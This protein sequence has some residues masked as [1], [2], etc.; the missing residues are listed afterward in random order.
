MNV[1]VD[2]YIFKQ[3]LSKDELGEL[4]LTVKS[5][6]LYI[7]RIM[8]RKKIEEKIGLWDNLKTAI[9]TVRNIN[10]KNIA[11]FV[12]VY[13]TKR[14]LYIVM[15][16][17][18]GGK[19]K[20]NIERY[21]IKYGKPFSEKISQHII[22]QLVDVNSFLHDKTKAKFDISL[23]NIYLNYFTEE[24]KNDL[25]M[26]HSNLK[27]YLWTAKKQN[28]ESDILTKTILCDFYPVMQDPLFK[29]FMSKSKKNMPE[30]IFD[31][32][33]NI[34]DVLNNL[35]IGDFF[36]IKNYAQEKKEYEFKISTNLSLETILLFTNIF[37]RV[38]KE[39]KD[40]NAK[41]FINHPFLQ[42]YFGDFTDF[43]KSNFSNYIKDE[44]LIVNINNIDEINSIINNQFNSEKK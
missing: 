39:K 36:F 12:Y 26:L 8:E 28:D 19:L 6:N 4:C 31:L 5:N 42:K 18:N 11:K 27:L 41:E 20:E 33:D 40:P 30:V 7:T 22:R 35:F 43:D 37:H 13:K 32:E 15:E 24:A 23:D 44:Y 21:K 16:Y 1:N 25:D 34:G 9:L 14:H 29:E 17:S 10:H 3:N 2:D 38:F